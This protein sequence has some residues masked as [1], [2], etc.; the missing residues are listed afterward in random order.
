MVLM[1]WVRWFICWIL[2]SM[3]YVCSIAIAMTGIQVSIDDVQI[4]A[5][6]SVQ[7]I[8]QVEHAIWEVDYA[9]YIDGESLDVRTGWLDL[10]WEAY[11]ELFPEDI[12]EDMITRVL[13]VQATDLWWTS[14]DSAALSIIY[15]EAICGDGKIQAPI[16]ECDDWNLMSFD[17]C[18]AS[19]L[20]EWICLPF[21]QW[22]KEF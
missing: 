22:D 17:W 7:I 9:W 1:R 10:S 20:C 6:E 18:S 4:V 8:A 11:T 21:L 3:M 16:E 19:C 5:G 14:T 15:D 12:H 2:V 13:T